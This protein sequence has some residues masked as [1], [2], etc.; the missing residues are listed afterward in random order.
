MITKN[1]N[2]TH[3]I[4]SLIL[5]FVMVISLSSCNKTVEKEYVT[6][7]YNVD[8][9]ENISID[10]I[11]SSISFVNA[12]ENKVVVKSQ[13]EVNVECKDNTLNLKNNTNSR[14][15]EIS[16][17]Y[18]LDNK[19]NLDYNSFY[20]N[21]NINKM[22]INNLNISFT[23]GK[24]EINENFITNSLIKVKYTMSCSICNN[25]MGKF[26]YDGDYNEEF[27]LL[28]NEI[29]DINVNVHKGTFVMD[30]THFKSLKCNYNLGRLFIR[31][32]GSVG[33][34]FMLNAPK[35]HFDFENYVKKENDKYIYYD[36]INNVDIKNIMNVTY[37]YKYNDYIG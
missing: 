1:K 24:L 8:K 13:E 11:N 28:K 18:N 19:I 3:K 33:Y 31:L 2:I 35:M 20:G 30:E 15:S 10:L 25:V 6:Y 36:G 17:L 27:K 12:T 9:F 7:E 26:S 23:Y 5:F 22:N 14:G 4:F 21:I 16:I 29:N 34:T 37:I 32:D